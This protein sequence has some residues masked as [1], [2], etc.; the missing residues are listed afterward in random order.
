[1]G[2][3]EAWSKPRALVAWYHPALLEPIFSISPSDYYHLAGLYE[4]LG[5]T[6]RAAQLF[7]FD[8]E[9][10]ES[11][12]DRARQ[13]IL[14]CAGL[15]AWKEVE[16][17]A[18]RSASPDFPEGYYW[19]GRG[20]MKLGHE[21]EGLSALR[22]AADL[23][24]EDADLQFRM[25]EASENMGDTAAA[26]TY[27]RQAVKLSPLHQAAWNNLSGLYR[28]PGQKN[29]VNPAATRADDLLPPLRAR[30]RFGNEIILLGS[31]LIP[32]V[33]HGEDEFGLTLYYRS[34]PGRDR[35]IRPLIRLRSTRSGKSVLLA[36]IPL[37]GS[38]GEEYLVAPI[39]IRVPRDIWPGETELSIGFLDPEGEPLRIFGERGYELPLAT[40]TV[41]PRLFRNDSEYRLDR[42]SV[43]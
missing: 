31:S 5:L 15:G 39:K 1:M 36:P 23:L 14:S 4:S 22:R 18:D 9:L 28:I 21:A 43:V 26:E 41:R 34:L 11:T 2:G 37:P 20:L 27:F 19:R 8:F 24:P 25:G 10:G 12:L 38:P 30:A 40:A 35:E 17:I 7:E 13:A 42:K 32:P 3:G 29:E 33:I 16:R 6:A